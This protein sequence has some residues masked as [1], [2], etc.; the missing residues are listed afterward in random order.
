MRCG[1]LSLLVRLQ[2]IAKEFMRVFNVAL[3]PVFTREHEVSADVV[4]ISIDDFVIPV[5][6]RTETV[7]KGQDLREESLHRL[8]IVGFQTTCREIMQKC[9]L[10][11][12]LGLGWFFPRFGCRIFPRTIIQLV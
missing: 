7:T 9:K 12:N 5:V 10:R 4:D 1:A 8:R 11:L 2:V 3:E 6:V